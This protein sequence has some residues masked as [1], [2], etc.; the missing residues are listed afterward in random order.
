MTSRRFFHAGIALLWAA[1]PAIYFQYQS[2]WDRLPARMATHFDINNHPNGWASRESSMWFIMGV[3]AFVTVIATIVTARI[4]RPDAASWAVLAMF[5]LILGVLYRA[6][7][8]VI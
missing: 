3:C 1:I 4:R 5:Y 6:S 2:V 8:A 7:A